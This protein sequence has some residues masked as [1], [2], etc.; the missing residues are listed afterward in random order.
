MKSSSPQGQEPELSE[1]D[2]NNE[3][4]KRARLRLEAIAPLLESLYPALLSRCE[5]KKLGKAQPRSTGGS[6]CGDG[7]ELEFNQCNQ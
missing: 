2:N 7:V 1:I 3:R 4:W 6:T 5:P